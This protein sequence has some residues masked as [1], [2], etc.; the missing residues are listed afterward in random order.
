MG[1][2][3]E[4][5]A[6]ADRDLHLDFTDRDLVLDLAAYAVMTGV[7]RNSSEIENIHAGMYKRPGM[8]KPR[9]LRD[10]EMFVGNIETA[11]LI[12]R[13]LATR[14]P[15]WFIAAEKDM[16]AYDRAYA[17]TP[18]TEHVTKKVLNENSKMVRHN[19]DL[20]AAVAEVIG[21]DRFLLGTALCAAVRGR[22]P[23][24]V[25]SCTV[26]AWLARTKDPGA[27]FDRLP[28]PLAGPENRDRLD[29]FV[30]TLKADPASI[31]LPTLQAALGC[32]LWGSRGG[33]PLWHQEHCEDPAHRLSAEVVQF[34]GGFL[35]GFDLYG[36]PLMWRY[37]AVHVPE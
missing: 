34:L 30:A 15:G 24:P 32:G 35:G 1:S 4:L 16:F 29:A 37:A 31:D 8:K 6:W 33:L 13:H 17:G 12:R 26:D 28:Q 11:R 36:L 10:S 23:S 3:E 25:W 7:W 18:L 22:Y 19:M 14:D 27:S 2:T 9:G 5:I 20:T 21:M